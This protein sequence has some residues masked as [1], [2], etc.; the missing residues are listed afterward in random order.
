MDR[1]TLAFYDRTASE[2]ASKYRAVD[3]SA[4]RQQFLDSFPAGGRI[5]DVGAGSGSDLALLISLGFDAYGTEPTEGM[6]TEAVRAFPQL[7]GRIFPFG[8]PLPEDAD[9]GGKFDGAVCSAVLMHVPETEL[10][11]ATFSLRRVLKEKGKLLISVS[12]PRPGVS[13]ENR[14]DTGRLLQLLD[15]EFLVLM[16]ER[17][18]SGA[19]VLQLIVH[20]RS[21]LK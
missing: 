14:D 15:P 8:L 5:L 6:R 7:Q 18:G 11:D 4:C 9:T 12:G 1:E 2:T 10:F 17:V 21:L 3:Q 16:F 13:L 19:S 20:G